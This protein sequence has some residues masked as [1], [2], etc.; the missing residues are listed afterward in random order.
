[1]QGIIY[2]ELPE[3]NW[4]VPGGCNSRVHIQLDPSGALNLVCNRQ[5]VSDRKRA[6]ASRR[7]IWNSLLE[8]QVVKIMVAICALN[9]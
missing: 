4:S 9:P 5:L 6:G 1:M 3:P 7:G 2:Q 8:S